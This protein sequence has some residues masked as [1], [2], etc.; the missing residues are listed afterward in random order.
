M[1][2]METKAVDKPRTSWPTLF[3]TGWMDKVFNAPIDEF[4]KVMPGESLYDIAQKQGMRLESLREL[5]SLGPDDRPAP[6][7]NLS[8][9]KKA[10]TS[11]KLLNL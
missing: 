10:A 2:N 7:E 6:G 9:R 1:F 3:D 11:H 8:L 5:N 4:F